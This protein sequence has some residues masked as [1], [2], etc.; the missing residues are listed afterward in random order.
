MHIFIFLHFGVKCDL[1][2][3]CDLH[4]GRFLMFS[5]S[6]EPISRS[7]VNLF[8]FFIKKSSLVFFSFYIPKAFFSH[9]PF[10]LCLYLLFCGCQS[11]NEILRFPQLFIRQICVNV[12]SLHLTGAVMMFGWRIRL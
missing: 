12:R 4:L 6:F 11:L 1:C 5:G 7:H 2:V 8:F 9:I 3:S 10:F